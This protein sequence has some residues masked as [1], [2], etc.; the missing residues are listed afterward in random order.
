MTRRTPFRISLLSS[1]TLAL[2]I[3]A[4]A[5]GPNID[6][7][8]LMRQAEQ[9]LKP[10][11]AK[12]ARPTGKTVPSAAA[13]VGD[14]SVRVQQFDFVG[15]ALL[16]TETLR[17][18]VAGFTNRSLTLT[19]LKEAADAITTSYRNAGW[20]VRAY[21]PKQEVSDGV[22]TIQIVETVFGGA[23]LQSA[24]P[25]RIDA[26]RL[27]D[28]AETLLPKGQPLHA[29][30]LDR[31]LLLLDD[32]PGVN[33]TGNLVE[34]QRDG[35][36]NVGIF[37]TDDN[38]LSGNASVDNQGSRATGVDR[39]SINLNLNSPARLGDALT[40]NGLKTQGSD[41]Q[42]LGYSV[43]VGAWG[44]RAGLH[45]SNLNYHVITPEFAS[46]HANGTAIARGWDLS[47]PLLR[48]Q[49]TN[50]NFALSYDDK[51]FENSSTNGNTAYGIKVYSASLNANQIDSWA[52]GGTSSASMTLT[53]GSKSTDSRYTKLNLNLSRLQSLND[54]LSLYIA[55]SSQNTN[56]NLDSSE[57]MYLGGATGVRAFPA[58]EAGGSEGKTFTL[59]LRQRLGDHVTWTGFYDYGWIKA[60]HDNDVSPPASP[61]SYHIQGY[62]M[63]LTWQVTPSFDVKTAVA[64]RLG[65]N[66]NAQANGNDSDGTKKI[67][68]IWLSSSLSF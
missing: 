48:S 44:W 53:S 10:T 28:M 24:T 18:A 49:L 35:E 39:L 66:P 3:T 57:K 41:Y 34:G 64:Q 6:A 9:E 4:Q 23:Q 25:Q 60:N 32:L 1:A 19:Q 67:T 13:K 63:S 11:K 54:S 62:G 26:A 58:S 12:P 61:N 31:A 40:I 42:R 22:V 30:D 2:S 47:Y 38:L 59:E 52:G 45:A 5:A 16:S 33:V 46:L 68:R 8:S 51:E 56:K 21:L 20:T 14:P 43:P 37:V 36:T 27:L 15:N 50:L 17:Q 65:D 7:G 29:N 55:A